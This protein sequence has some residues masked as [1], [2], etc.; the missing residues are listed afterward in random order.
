M[1]RNANKYQQIDITPNI[2]IDEYIL[3]TM[4]RPSL[5]LQLLS[6][7]LRWAKDNKK[8][9]VFKTHPIP[10]D[11]VD[12]SVYWDQ[13]KEQ[14]L[15]SEYSHLISDVNTDLLVDNCK[16]VWTMSSG[17]GCQAVL[18]GKPVSYFQNDYD[19]TYG[20]VAKYCDTADEAYDN[21]INLENVERY[22]SW[23]YYKF[24]IDMQRFD[25]KELI[26]KR[27]NEFYNEHKTAEQMF[28]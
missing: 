12:F 14:G 6:D 23:Y 16:M 5:Q 15:V 28:T 4:Q 18:K 25:Y 27:F 1:R 17:V 22:F 26:N 19:F 24:A 20:P 7:C 9:I 21:T 11:S 8:H 10:V 3:F 13:F 2:N